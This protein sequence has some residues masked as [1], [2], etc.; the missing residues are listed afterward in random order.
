MSVDLVESQG[1]FLSCSYG[2]RQLY[3]SSR[4]CTTMHPMP[5]QR[6][7]EPEKPEDPKED[8]PLVPPRHRFIECD[9]QGLEQVQD[10]PC[11]IELHTATARHVCHF[12]MSHLRSGYL[13][14]LA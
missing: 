2:A 3:R 7:Q 1:E 14:R 6:Q 8:L 10:D 4:A 11:L 13:H 9:E 12:G 5:S